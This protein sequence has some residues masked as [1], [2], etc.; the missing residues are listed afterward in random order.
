VSKQLYLTEWIA[1][2]A[3]YLKKDQVPPADYYFT[4]TH[5]ASTVRA[6]I[7][8]IDTLDDTLPEIDDL[9][10][11]ACIFALDGMVAQFQIQIEAGNVQVKKLLQL[12]MDALAE[13]FNMRKHSLS[14]WMPVISIF[15]EMHIELSSP[16]KDAYLA[17][18]EDESYE[19]E[20]DPNFDIEATEA[21]VGLLSELDH[22]SVFDIAENLFAQSYALPPDF[23]TSLVLALYEEPHGVDIAILSLAHPDPAIRHVML[24]LHDSVLQEITLTSASLSRLE[25]IKHWYPEEHHPRFNRWIKAQRRQGVVYPPHITPPQMKLQA[26]EVDGGGAQ[27][28]FIQVSEPAGHRLGNIL[29]KQGIGI[30]DVWI[31]PYI[32][33]T[34]MKG[35]LKEAFDGNVTLRTVDLPYLLRL[36]NHFL[37]LMLIQETL[38]NVHLLELQEI[39]GIQFK[40]EPIDLDSLIEALAIQ[41]RPFTQETIETALKRSGKWSKH[42]SFTESWYLENGAVDKIVNRHCNIVGGV[43]LCHFG[44][45]ATTLFASLF[46]T[47]RSWWCFHFLWLTLWAMALPKKNETLGLDCFCIAYAIHQGKPLHEIPLMQAI[48][49]QTIVNSMETMEE[50]RTHL[51]TE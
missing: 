10:Y 27:G 50:R 16:L 45:A 49:E 5:D 46:E 11:S 43:K 23:L 40:P 39:L 47:Q 2:I 22:L 17:L 25:Q 13:A 28:L 35:Y 21:L 34:H 42:K 31:T 9:T 37:G 26:S 15:Y 8:M 29:F 33:K 30:K 51:N 7:Q 32:K 6:L 19:M 20:D 14:F 4:T 12:L 18:A 41:I 44:N 1:N 24:D 38:P 48:A 36:V 3:S